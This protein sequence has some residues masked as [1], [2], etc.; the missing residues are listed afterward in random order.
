MTQHISIRHVQ[1]ADIAFIN[2]LWSVVTDE[3]LGRLG[4]LK[5]PDPDATRDFLTWFCA[6]E[7]AAV[8]AGEDLR[9]WCLDAKPYGY[10]TLK[11]FEHGGSG[12]I[13]L[14]MHRNHWGR[15]LGAEPF[16]ASAR[17]FLAAHRLRTLSC[18]PHAD[19]PMPNRMLR[20]LG[21]KVERQVTYERGDGS[22]IVLNKYL[23]LKAPTA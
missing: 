7:N 23:I 19:N 11:N 22:K 8:L 5:R 3:D 18:S 10:A 2:E 20:K 1:V 6:T 17:E 16:L 4:E 15:G 12:E 9:I 14:H 13:H 21:Y